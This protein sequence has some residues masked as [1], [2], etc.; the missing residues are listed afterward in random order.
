MDGADPQVEQVIIEYL[1]GLMQKA[2][3][4]R[5][6]KVMSPPVEGSPQEESGEPSDEQML[7]LAQASG[8]PGHEMP[9]GTQMDDAEMDPE[10]EK[11][12]RLL[13]GR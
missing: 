6:E 3:G 1:R 8:L 12:R 2:Q 9:D 7:E 4:D 13:M 5:A 10:K 11:K